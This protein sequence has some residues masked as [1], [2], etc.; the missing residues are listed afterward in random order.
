LLMPVFSRWALMFGMAPQ[1]VLHDHRRPYPDAT[2]PSLHRECRIIQR[3]RM[4][5][6]TG[7]Q[8]PN[9]ATVN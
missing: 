9:V 7:L 6:R 1:S 4:S 8:S 3:W 2:V 5:T